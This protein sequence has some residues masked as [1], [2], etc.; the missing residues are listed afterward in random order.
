MRALPLIVAFKHCFW[1]RRRAVVVEV[2]RGRRR[3]LALILAGFASVRLRAEEPPMIAFSNRAHL[4]V[5]PDVRDELT[6]CL[7]H[8]FGCADPSSLK[9]PGL[10]EP[11]LAFRFPGGGSMSFEF[12]SDALTESE[13]MRGAWME[14]K[15]DELN[16]LRAAITGAG[17]KRVHHPASDT[18]YCVLPGGQVLGIVAAT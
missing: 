11:I 10:S 8:V 1:W 9:T 5:R 14:V 15:T 12:R 7:T 3:F 4:A 17:M 18:F 16:R 2:P 13:V 6:R